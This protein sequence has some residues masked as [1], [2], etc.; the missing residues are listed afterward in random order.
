LEK[1]C[2]WQSKDYTGGDFCP[3]LEICP[4]PFPSPRDSGGEG[5]GHFA[6]TVRATF[7]LNQQTFPKISVSAHWIFRGQLTYN[8]FALDVSKFR[9]PFL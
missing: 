9:A 5:K 8:L 4:S 3:L 7:R 6:G 1:R 2:E